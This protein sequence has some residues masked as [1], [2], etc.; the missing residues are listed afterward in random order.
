MSC[1][2]KKSPK[3]R[4]LYTKDL[5]INKNI[6]NGAKIIKTIKGVPTIME[7]NT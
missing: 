6:Y 1:I 2:N 4:R 7:L 5:H 3:E